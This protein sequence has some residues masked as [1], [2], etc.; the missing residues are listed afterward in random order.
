MLYVSRNEYQDEDISLDISR[1]IEYKDL[2]RSGYSGGSSSAGHVG[3]QEIADN[4]SALYISRH[5][6]EDDDHANV[7]Y[8]S[9]S[10]YK[11]QDDVQYVSRNRFSS[12]RSPTRVLPSELR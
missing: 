7:D 11:D 8:I 1:E 6:Y 4:P 3:R 12:N 5:E 2:N 9:K 10:R